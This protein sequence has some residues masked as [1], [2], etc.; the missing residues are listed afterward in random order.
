MEIVILW[1]PVYNG[2]K[3]ASV[4]ATIYDR[5]YC[6]ICWVRKTLDS[7][8]TFP[9]ID[10]I[11]EASPVH[12][13]DSVCFAVLKRRLKPDAPRYSPITRFTRGVSAVRS[14]SKSHTRMHREC[15]IY[16]N[17]KAALISNLFKRFIHLEKPVLF[18]QNSKYKYM[19]FFK[20]FESIFAHGFRY[21]KG[22]TLGD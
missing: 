16:R 4:E 22:K 21:Y 11:V 17:S 19:V 5:R 18:I 6:S 1:G 10:Y 12:T 15:G 20:Y 7:C 2:T 8:Y 3:I 13:V 14:V 9:T